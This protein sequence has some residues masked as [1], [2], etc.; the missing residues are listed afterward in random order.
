MSR[1]ALITGC[2]SGIG[3]ACARRFAEAGFTVFATARRVEAL[4][5]LAAI[6]C[7]TR[8]LDVTDAAA[9]E[10]VV[11]EI[12]AG[13]GSVEVLVNNAGYGQQ[14]AFEETPLEAV[15][16][17]LETNLIG[18]IAVTQRV[19]PRMRER[20]RGRI[21]MMSSM[22]GRI[23]FPG[24]ASYHASKYALEAVSDVLRFE[25]ARFG[26]D[27]VIVEP[28]LVASDYGK[29]SLDR[30][31]GRESGAYAAFSRGLRAALTRSFAGEVPGISTPDE[32]AKACLDAATAQPAP[33]RIVVGSMAQEL[34]RLRGSLGDHGWDALLETMYPRPEPAPEP[35]PD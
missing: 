11:A 17:Q 6:G 21:L 25:V 30:L 31:A 4:A 3:A 23:A 18:A 12:E 10:R 29:T 16:A 7:L 13:H 1:T 22:G 14:G 26:I 33:T 35:E 27:V 19:L 28:G 20:R 2:S 34:I 24:G 5:D 15:R 8:S 9:L 32:V